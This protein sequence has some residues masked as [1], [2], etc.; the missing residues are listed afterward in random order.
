MYVNLYME[1]QKSQK[2]RSEVKIKIKNKFNRSS[3]DASKTLAQ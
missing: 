1:F 2:M 3:K